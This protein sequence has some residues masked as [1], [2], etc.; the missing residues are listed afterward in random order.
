MKTI[1]I[2]SLDYVV[3]FSNEIEENNINDFLIVMDNTFGKNTINKDEFNRKYINNIYGESILVIVYANKSPVAARGFWRND[4]NAKKAFQPCDTCVIK[5]Y[6]GKGI[7][8]QMTKCALEYVSND[9]VY[10]YPNKNSY[11]LYIK[12]G[13]EITVEY[14]PILL[15]SIEKYKKE[16]PEI[17]DNEYLKWWLLPKNYKY[18]YL[19][20]RSQVF[21]VKKG[22]LNRYFILGTIENKMKEYFKEARPLLPILLY[23]SENKTFYNRNKE[24][25][26]MVIKN[27]KDFKNNKIPIYKVDAI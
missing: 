2:G 11:P 26:R 16:H 3:C 1:R 24:P 18:Y 10:N 4:I 8:N 22:K 20:Y 19:E 23:W 21:L 5:E 17:I 14:R 27:D 12:M 25:M 13:W 9:I 7:F 15:T 6:R